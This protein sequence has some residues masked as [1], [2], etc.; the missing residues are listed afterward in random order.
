MFSQNSDTHSQKKFNFITT[1]LFKLSKT[2]V[3]ILSQAFQGGENSKRV[4]LVQ[5][6]LGNTCNKFKQ[7]T[8]K[9][10]FYFVYN[11]PVFFDLRYLKL[12]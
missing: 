9:K 4:E 10:S 2:F 8:F 5:K 11:I 1:L 7:L 3:K 6:C 12:Y